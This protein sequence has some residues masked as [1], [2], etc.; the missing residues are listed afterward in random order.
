VDGAIL[1]AGFTEFAVLYT[2][3][4]STGVGDESGG[5]HSIQ[6]YGSVYTD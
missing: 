5:I 4:K 3:F 2:P 6:T 1:V